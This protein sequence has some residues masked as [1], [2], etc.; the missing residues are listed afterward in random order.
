M[1]G[2][3]PVRAGRSVSTSLSAPIALHTSTV[4]GR[5]FCF[6]G[7]SPILT[8]RK[9]CVRSYSLSSSSIGDLISRL[10]Q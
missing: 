8:H 5:L 10:N 3:N 6:T 2:S 4:Y 9:G 1:L 7:V